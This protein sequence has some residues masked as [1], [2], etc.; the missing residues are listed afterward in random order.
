M[1]K[2]LDSWLCNLYFEIEKIN[3]MDLKADE[4]TGRLYFS[5]LYKL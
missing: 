3:L 1:M 4:R 5:P 2:D